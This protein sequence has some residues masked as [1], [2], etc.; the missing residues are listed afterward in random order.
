V[1][2]YSQ[3]EVS[4]VTSLQLTGFCLHLLLT[5]SYIRRREFR[6]YARSICLVTLIGV[7]IFIA[8]WSTGH[9]TN[10][11]GRFLYF[12]ATHPNLGGEIIAAGIF[13]AGFALNRVWFLSFAGLSV[14]PLL[15]LQARSAV[16]VDLYLV[17]LVVYYNF[18]HN[19]TYKVRLAFVLLFSIA[20]VLAIGLSGGVIQDL[21]LADD[22]YRGVGTEFSGRGQLWQ[23]AWNAFYENPYFGKGYGYY[24]A[25][26]SVGAH[27]V[28]LFILSEDG[29]LGLIILGWLAHGIFR[30][31]FTKHREILW[32]SSF[33]ILAI[34]NDRFANLNPYPF[35][36]YVVFW[37]PPWLI[38]VRCLATRQSEQEFWG[39]GDGKYR[40]LISKERF[41]RPVQGIKSS[42]TI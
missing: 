32:T 25:I 22:Q 24:D 30:Y 26:G 31:G 1:V 14:L 7:L 33:L 21:F 27:N 2:A 29:L 35:V 5:G 42:A 20:G 17:V 41:R 3:R 6:A 8:Q 16:V 9:L 34:F 36:Y 19:R 38:K 28:L 18:V 10:V 11:Y 40:Q 39:S 13:V 12:G 15:L 23:F 37:L 4:A